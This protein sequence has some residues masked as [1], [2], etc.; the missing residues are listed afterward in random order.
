MKLQHLL[1]A[2]SAIG[3]VGAQAQGLHRGNDSAPHAV[4]ATCSEASGEKRLARLSEDYIEVR[5]GSTTQSIPLSDI[6]SIDVTGPVNRISRVAWVA[7][8]M[9][10]GTPESVGLPLTHGASVVLDGF[11]PQG[12]TDSIDLLDCKRVSF[13]SAG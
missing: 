13:S 12:G 11:S 5:S 2:M 4:Q 9:R 1:L 3:A 6:E 8:K 10:G 7:L